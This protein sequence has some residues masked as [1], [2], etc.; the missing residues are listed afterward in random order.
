M[1]TARKILTSAL[2]VPFAAFCVFGFSAS[3]EPGVHTAWKVGYAVLFSIACA[4][5]VVLWTRRSSER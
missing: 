4:A 5:L 1:T 3:F 2:V